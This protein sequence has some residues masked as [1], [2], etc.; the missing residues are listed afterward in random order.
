MEIVFE[1]LSYLPF[2][3]AFFMIFSLGLEIVR[4]GSI[5]AIALQGP[6][7]AMATL[8]ENEVFGE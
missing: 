7:S 3:S 8:S 1:F 6:N 5:G 4:R 2:V